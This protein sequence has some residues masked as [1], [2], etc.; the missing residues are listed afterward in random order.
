MKDD[1]TT[2]LFSLHPDYG[3]SEPVIRY[4]QNL[5]RQHTE[6]TIYFMH[7][8]EVFHHITGKQAV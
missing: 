3:D 2:D 6:D 5:S 1:K 4:N 8:Q 7:G